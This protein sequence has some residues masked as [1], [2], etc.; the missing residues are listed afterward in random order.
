[1]PADWLPA[2]SFSGATS[3]VVWN[4]ISPRVG[5]TYDLGGVGRTVAKGSFAVYYGQRS[6][7]QAVS[8]LN[9]VTAASVRFPWSDLNGDL[10]VQRNELTLGR[11]NVLF[12]S[13]NY[14][15][16]DP[17]ALTTTGSVD[18]NVKNDRTREFIVGVDHELRRNLG[19]GVS[20]IWRKYDQMAWNDTLDFDSDDYV[21]R[22]FTPTASQCPV[23][24]ARCGAITYFEPA[25]P[26]PAPFLYTNQ[27]D[28]YRNYKGVELTATKRYADRW[29][30]SFS[31]AFNDARDFW[32]SPRA[33]EDPTQIPFLHDAQFAPESGGS[34]I[35]NIFTNS[36]WLVKLQGM[37][38]VPRVEINLAGYY[39]ARQGYP[40]P[41]ALRVTR[42]NRGGTIDV[43]LDPMG[44]IRHPNLH[45]A[46]FR[47]ERAF[48][49]RGTRF[50]P[51]LDIFNVGNVNTVLARRRLQAAT[52][53]NRISGIVAPRVIRFGVRVN[54]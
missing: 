49:I 10:I 33:Y 45:Y 38:T 31:F 46:D 36:K 42:A 21:A 4:D 2:I 34:G 37:Y 50:V 28:R 14:N 25:F 7:G 52:N 48:A 19:V 53:A 5:F 3:P 9:P 22:T 44:E 16:D 15:P 13:G 41:Q 11:S 24:G 29:M 27:P 6:P 26:V 51:S 54:W 12:F 40:F 43:L 20:Y 30:G 18:P 1:M 39:Q 8:P 17:T 47:V 23:A 32:G 35:D